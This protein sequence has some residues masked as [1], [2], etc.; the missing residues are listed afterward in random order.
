M[1]SPEI[2][3]PGVD[4]DASLVIAWRAGNHYEGR[5]VPIAGDVLRGFISFAQ[6]ATD[7]VTSG[8]GVVYTPD[9]TQDD[10][11]YMTVD[12]SDFDDDALIATL[13]SYGTLDPAEKEDLQRRLVCYAFIVEGPQG[14]TLYIRR[15]DPVML[16]G[17][18]LVARFLGESLD[19]I[20]EPILAFDEKFDLILSIQQGYILNASRFEQLMKSSEV[21][22]TKIT[23]W[24]N[25]IEAALPLQ[26]GS[27][28]VLEVA[29]RG[30]WFYRRKLESVIG[31]DYFT[32]LTIDHIKSAI[33][34]HELD[35]SSY[36]LNDELFV[37]ENTVRDVLR[38]LNEDFFE[39]DFSGGQFAASS[40][41]RVK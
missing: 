7:G 20:A 10:L 11:A 36:L 23:T 24:T 1:D 34:K 39:G 21:V 25:K 16:A 17:K 40:K 32:Q 4:A 2:E 33:A 26:A 13:R 27:R 38:L 3:R 19:K 29:V 35:E 5:T 37:D 9:A 30:N 22:A 41:T 28:E 12:S 18:S 31:S 6:S 8:Q 15:V 14:P